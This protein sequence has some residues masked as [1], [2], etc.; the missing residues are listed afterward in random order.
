MENNP[1][2]RYWVLVGM[3]LIAGFSQGML[4]PVLAVMLEGAGVSSSANGLNAAALYM[5]II[6]ISPFIE[7]PVRKYGY[8]PVI[9]IGLVLVTISVMLFPLWQAFWFW[10][11]LR[12]VVGIADNLI[13]F[14]TQVWISTTST[15]EKRGRQLALYGLAFG[16]GFGLGP[17]MTRLLEIHQFLPFI[18]SAVMSLIAF[19]FMLLLKNEWPVKE[20]ATASKMGTFSRYKKVIKLA[21]FALLPGFC[22]GYLEASLHGNYPVYAL[23][24]GIDI[25]LTTM[26]LLPGFVFGSLVTQLP[27]GILSDKLGRSRVLLTLMG[28]GGL[29]FMLMP[30]IEQYPIVLF[31]GFVI[32]G[33][34]LGSLFSLGITYL[35]DLVP[36]SLLPT[37]N[38]MTA[39]LFGFGSMTGPIVGGILIEVIGSG[40]IYYSISAMLGLMVA[41][42][43]IFEFQQLKEEKKA[44]A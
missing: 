44:A 16:M 12:M 2:F 27:L 43:C 39:V 3:V 10:F 22:Y 26:F 19:G 40:A 11:V 17:M 42:G 38:V 6:L 7:A 1:V 25:Q 13:H 21:W 35:A 31:S 23:R 5:G 37:G 34:L 18:I 4:L 8:K 33:M 30:L 9:L 36:A 24:M 28:T 32:T 15:P 29:L 14:S 20:L 41:A